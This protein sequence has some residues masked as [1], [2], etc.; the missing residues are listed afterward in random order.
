MSFKKQCFHIKTP[1]ENDSLKRSP[2]F[3]DSH[4]YRFAL[5]GQQKKIIQINNMVYS[6]S[7]S[8]SAKLASRQ[9]L[10]NSK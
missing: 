4:G 10:H 8:D 7:V 5:Q 2:L 1:E 6:S 9:G 3:F